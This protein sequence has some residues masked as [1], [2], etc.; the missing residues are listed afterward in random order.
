MLPV[1]NGSGS[2]HASAAK[3]EPELTVGGARTDGLNSAMAW[4][5]R[6]NQFKLFELP[7]GKKTNSSCDPLHV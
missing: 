4:E 3:S 2:L 6:R 5:A 7:S 1:S